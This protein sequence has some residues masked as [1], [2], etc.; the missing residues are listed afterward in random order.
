M[1]SHPSSYIKEFTVTLSGEKL[2]IQKDYA[3]SLSKFWAVRGNEGRNRSNVLEMCLLACLDSPLVYH[4]ESTCILIDALSKE[5]Q[6]PSTQILP[7]SVYTRVLEILQTHPSVLFCD[8]KDGS[9]LDKRT[10]QFIFESLLSGFDLAAD[11][12]ME[13]SGKTAASAVVDLWRKA[14]PL[15][16][17]V[18]SPTIHSMRLTVQ[19]AG[20]LVSGGISSLPGKLTP[21]VR[22]LMTSIQNEHDDQ[23]QIVACSSMHNFMQILFGPAPADRTKGFQKT[24]CKSSSESL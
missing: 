2:Q 21:I 16:Q 9:F 5:T 20:A 12:V 19:L 7:S 6:V 4:C 18:T 13:E 22:P 8:Q 23:C 1:K 10:F 11:K 15:Q 3:I 14:L 24:C 17:Q